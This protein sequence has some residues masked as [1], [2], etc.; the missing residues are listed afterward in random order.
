M[1]L[2]KT[3]TTQHGFEAK[4]A[5]HRVEGVHLDSKIKMSFQVNS[6]KSQESEAAFSNAALACD[7]DM[8]GAN[9]IAQAYAYLKTLPEFADAT[10]C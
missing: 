1:A 9:P 5:Y 6:Y 3:V 4:D 2:K 7:Y 8:Q 10:D